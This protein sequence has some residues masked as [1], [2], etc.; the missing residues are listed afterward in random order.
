MA[1]N[2]LTLFSH[3]LVS[4][5]KDCFL[6]LHA[7]LVV[8]DL[9]IVPEGSF[10]VSPAQLYLEHLASRSVGRKTT[11]ALLAGPAHTDQE[12]MTTVHSQDTVDPGQMVQ[13]IVEENKVHRGVVFIVLFQNL[14]KEYNVQY[15]TRKTKCDTIHKAIDTFQYNLSVNVN[16]DNYCLFEFISVFINIVHVQWSAHSCQKYE[17]SSFDYCDLHVS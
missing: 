1:L 6:V 8:Q 7:Q 12:G 11:Q 15:T 14:Q 17:G 3:M 16:I 5:Q 10:I 4:E 2:D 13:G 9:Q